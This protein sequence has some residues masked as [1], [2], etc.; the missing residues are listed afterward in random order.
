[1]TPVTRMAPTPSGYLHLGNA[2]SFAIAWLCARSAG[3][4]VILRIDD[5]DT[6]RLRPEYVEDVF[7]SLEWLGLDWDEGPRDAGDFR[8]H[9][10]QR[11]RF[12]VYRSALDRLLPLTVPQGSLVY[13]CRCSREK[14]KRDA[15]AAGTGVLYAG[16]CRC[17]DLDR[18]SLE[19]A[20]RLRVS[21]SDAVTVRDLAA[22]PLTLEPAKDMGDFV[23]RR[24][25]GDPAYQLAS[26]IDDEAMGV[27]LVVRGLDLLP[28]TGAQALLARH[29]GAEKFLRADFLHH[30][31]ILSG[32]GEKLSKSAGDPSLASLRA[33]LGKP[34]AVHRHFARLLG[35]DP[36]GV[37]TARDLLPSFTTARVPTGPLGWKDFLA[38]LT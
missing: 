6:A 5:L 13:G 27:N 35:I 37:R 15:E 11:L 17:L 29:L 4:R 23:L 36:A 32:E 26:L 25:G 12:D 14:A 18:S 22:G 31:L 33:R 38:S 28:S 21:K 34:E 9:H 3:G 20:L 7:A 19:Y 10:S 8:E 2:W 24:R 30:G 16:T 1:M